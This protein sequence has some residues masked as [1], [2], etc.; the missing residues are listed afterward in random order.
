MKYFPTYELGLF[1]S[2][3]RYAKK[4]KHP[5][6]RY[7]ITHIQ[8]GKGNLYSMIFSYANIASG[9][10]GSIKGGSLKFVDNIEKKYYALGGKCL[11]NSPVKKV[12]FRFRRATGVTLSP[13]DNISHNSK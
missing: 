13:L 12:N 1:S 11:L 5:A 3:D 10:G 8:P 9:N 4:F 2:C 6:L 7:A